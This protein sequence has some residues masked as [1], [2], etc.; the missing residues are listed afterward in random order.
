MRIWILIIIAWSRNGEGVSVSVT[1][2]LTEA[3]CRIVATASRPMTPP[4]ETGNYVFSSCVSA[5]R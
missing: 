5:Y 3:E 2:D 4:V 1:R